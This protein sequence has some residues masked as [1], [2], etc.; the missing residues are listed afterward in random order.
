MILDADLINS[1]C[2][3]KMNAQ[4]LRE[5]VGNIQHQISKKYVFADIADSISAFLEARLSTGEYDAA[6]TPEELA[7]AIT[8]DLRHVSNDE[9]LRVRYFVE[10]HMPETDGDA[11]FEQNDRQQHVEQI[12][13]GISKIEFL[14]GNIGYI[15]FREFV[16]HGKAA[17]Y[18]TAAMTLLAKSNAL[19]IDLRNC[20]GGDPATVTWLCSYLFNKRTSLSALHLRQNNKVEQFHTQ[21][22]VPGQRFGEEKPVYLLLA[23]YTFSGAEMLAY[24]L[25]ATGR[26]TVIGE[27]SGGGA[28]ACQF[29]WPTPHF[30]LL[31][32]VA[33][34]ISPISK[35][36]WEK[37]G[38][39]PDIPV[40]ANDA[41][42][43]AYDLAIADINSHT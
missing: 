39:K 5:L 25:Q 26:A 12:S 28:H 37:V 15:A 10:P 13:F 43:T 19:I 32:P 14:E 36:N 17:E 1:K 42:V 3:I 7:S 4:A 34:P 23:H 18:I 30:S 20:C 31:L 41:L 16:E 21:D 27:T 22:W 2:V 24:D 9:H 8:A 6:S 35:A 40:N 33:Q 29:V 38:V 11:V